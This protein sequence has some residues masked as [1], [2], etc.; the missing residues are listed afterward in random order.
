MKVEIHKLNN[1]I[2]TLELE[3]SSTH[4]FTN[5]HVTELDILINKLVEFN[6]RNRPR[7]DEDDFCSG[8]N[9]SFT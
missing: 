4:S 1:G 3:T 8:D 2:I 6:K 5:F 9:C 7:Y